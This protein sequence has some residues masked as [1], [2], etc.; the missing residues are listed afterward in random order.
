MI[1]IS[2][3]LCGIDCK[4]NGDNNNHPYFIAMSQQDKALL[5]CPEEMGGLCTPRKPC[6]I[7][8]GTGYDV[9]QGAARVINSDNVD[10][11]ESFVNGAHHVLQLAQDSNVEVAILQNRS[12]SCGVGHIYDGTFNKKLIE[13]DGVTTA[14]LRQNGIKV[15]TATDYLQEKGV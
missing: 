2:A 4:Y 15:I 6:E 12:P 11:T 1:L 9:L 3:C 10:V 7:V 14:L 5:V 8:G 13:G